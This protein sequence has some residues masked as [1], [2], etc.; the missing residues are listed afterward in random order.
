MHRSDIATLFALGAALLIAIGDVIQQRSAHDVT[1]EQVGP[2]ALFLHLL[3][4]K[5]WWLGSLV[6]AGGFG[7]QAAALGFGSVLLVQALIVT[8]LL[9]ALPL[10][11]RFAGRRI[12][13]YQWIWAV[14][15]AAA[16]AVIVTVG[17][18]SKGQ[19]RAGV[20]MW[21][22]VAAT[23]GPLLLLCLLGSRVFRGKPVAAVLL[24]VVAGSLWGLFAVLMKGVVDELDDGIVA[25]LKLP[26]LYVWAVV[27]IAATA[28]QQASF[29]AGSMAASLPAVTVSEPMVASVLGVAI[30]GEMLRPGRSGWAFLVIAV[31]VMIA[32]TV[33]LA[34]TEAAPVPDPAGPVPS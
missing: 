32:A 25:V 31:V 4:D 2:I 8:S 17:D 18:P 1:D 13:R 3:R 9:F 33:E 6:A 24:G 11:A 28:I 21:S 20:D 29:R 30:L 10:S 27:A 5:T 23:L 12:T 34:R 15:L 7:L 16:V 26:E 19:A 14:L 22:W